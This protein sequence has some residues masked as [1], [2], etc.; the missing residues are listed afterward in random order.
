MPNTLY[1]DIKNI[2]D[3]ATYFVGNIFKRTCPHSFY[4]QLNGFKYFCLPRIVYQKFHLKNVLELICLHIGILIVSVKLNGFNYRYL[5]LIMPYNINHLF[6]DCE[7]VA[8]I[9]LV[10]FGF[11]AHQP[12]QVI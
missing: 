2:Y 10:C 6:A 7:L 5:T 3:F 4:T 11:M 1:T 12:L 9:G 8:S